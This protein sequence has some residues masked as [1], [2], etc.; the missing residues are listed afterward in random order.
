MN[1]SAATMTRW[2]QMK[3]VNPKKDTEIL[4]YC[5]PS[6]VNPMP[7]RVVLYYENT[8]D[9]IW[10]DNDGNDWHYPTHFLRISND[11]K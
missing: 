5:T 4:A 8:D 2:I 7:Y 6:I 3:N 1:G 11:P 10:V 9:P